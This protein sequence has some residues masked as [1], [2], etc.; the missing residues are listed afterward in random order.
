MARKNIPQMIAAH[1]TGA[2][3]GSSSARVRG[4]STGPSMNMS[5]PPSAPPGASTGLPVRCSHRPHAGEAGIRLDAVGFRVRLR[6]RA[7]KADG[8]DGRQR[9]PPPR[10]RIGGV[11]PLVMV[12]TDTRRRPP[13]PP[14]GSAYD[15]RMMKLWGS[16]GRGPGGDPSWL[17]GKDRDGADS[18]GSGGWSSDFGDGAQ[19]PDSDFGGGDFG[20]GGSGGGNFGGGTDAQAAQSMA[21]RF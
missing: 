19:R 1:L 13:V 5:V 18:Q 17:G 11:A 20:G 3:A 16:D 7:G 6:C 21:P 10:R 12:G 4:G 15:G 9:A 14:R 8:P 2:R